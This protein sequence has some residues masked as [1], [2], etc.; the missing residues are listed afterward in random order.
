MDKVQKTI[1][2]QYESV[3]GYCFSSLG[4]YHSSLRCRLKYNWLGIESND[5]LC[6]FLAVYKQ[7]DSKLVVW[8]M[9]DFQ[10][11][12][13]LSAAEIAYRGIRLENRLEWLDT[14]FE[15]KDP[16]LFDNIILEF[17]HNH[18]MFQER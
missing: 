12:G 7:E 11:N 3:S 8:I 4:K 15:G 16:G 10:F 6:R 13:A 14:C 2:S 9:V 18:W 17:A 5:L 1:G